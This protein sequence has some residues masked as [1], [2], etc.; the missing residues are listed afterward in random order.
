MD[1]ATIAFLSALLGAVVGALASAV[2]T[3][4]VDRAR[5]RRTIRARQLRE[6]IPPVLGAAEA[7]LE[8]LEKNR[9]PHPSLS[10]ISAALGAVERE[11]LVAGR[12]DAARGRY[13][14]ELA[15]ELVELEERLWESNSLSRELAVTTS[16]AIEEQT[17]MLVRVLG[18]V[19]KYDHWLRS[20]MLKPWWQRRPDLLS[21]YLDETKG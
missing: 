20:H 8:F 1:S 10:H 21:P 2:G 16:E 13:L 19:R 3:M 6:L 14:R 12:E 11:A 9:G 15:E 7:G 5:A 18:R 4:A 17:R